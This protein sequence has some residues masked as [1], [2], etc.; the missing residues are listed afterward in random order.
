M[1]KEREKEILHSTFLMFAAASGGKKT[2]PL[3]SRYHVSY[4]RAAERTLSFMGVFAV[5]PLTIRRNQFDPVPRKWLCKESLTS[6]LHPSL[7]YLIICMPFPFL[8]SFVFISLAC[9]GLCPAQRPCQA[10]NPLLPPSHKPRKW[11]QQRFSGVQAAARSRLLI[12][13]AFVAA[14]KV[15]AF[16]DL[17]SCVCYVNRNNLPIQ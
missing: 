14:R 5:T 13:S 10:E 3:A 7:L 11:L 17:I 6:S 4:Y 15:H 8:A 9:D 16:Y 1:I 2:A 12:Q